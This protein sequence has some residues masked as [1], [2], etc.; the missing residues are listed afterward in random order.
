M[1]RQLLVL[2]FVLLVTAPLPSAAV[3][4]VSPRGLHSL[5]EGALLGLEEEA[6]RLRGRDPAPAGAVK[7]QAPDAGSGDD[8]LQPALV[9]EDGASPVMPPVGP[10]KSRPM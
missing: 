1:P 3:P 5:P 7:P 2:L 10:V 4:P 9:T 8:D 6:A